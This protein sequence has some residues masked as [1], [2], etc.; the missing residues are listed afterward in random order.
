VWIVLGL[1]ALGAVVATFALRGPQEMTLGAVERY[2]NNLPR[3]HAEGPQTYAQSPPVGGTHSG[4]WQNCGVYDQP[5]RNESA[6]H[7]LEH[8]AVW[9]TYRPDLPAADVEALRALVRGQ[10]YMLLSPYQNLQAPLAATAW[11]AQLF[12]DNARDPKLGAFI[13]TYLQGAQTPE[14]GAP[15]SGGTGAPLQ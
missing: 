9:I 15:C 6:V 14:P 8:G 1:V 5:V 2:G 7:S 11:G 4:T 12:L 13:D 3:T 10:S